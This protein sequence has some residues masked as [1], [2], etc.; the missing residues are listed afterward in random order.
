MRKA[1]YIVGAKR[2]PFGAYGGKLKSFSPTDL[3]VLSSKAAIGQAKL[4][5]AL[6]DDTFFGNVI[7][8]S[9]D[10]TYLA[11][12]I[13]LRSGAPISSPALTVNRLCGS[14]FEAACLAAES[15]EGDRA[16]IALAGGTE[17]MSAAPM[18]IDGV[19][20]RFGVALGKGLQAQDSLWAGLTDSYA[21][22]PMGVTAENL[23]TKYNISRG[24]CDEYALRSQQNWK[25]A[26]MAGVFTAEIE[27]VEVKGKKGKEMMV[28]DEHPRPETT[29][30]GL[31]KLKPV[32]KE[33]GT[34]TAGTASGISDGSASLILASESA[35]SKEKLVPLARMVSWARVGCDPSIMGIGPVEAI[36]LALKRANLQLGDMG[37]YTF[38]LLY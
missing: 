5:P 7:Q 20:A 16:S 33:G 29:I 12:H 8:S 6:I 26:Q 18:V 2:T 25:K 1:I 24:E 9:L 23:A 19:S 27:P 35:C 28:D 4:N 38:S 15:I 17:N 32:F 3:G 22:F 10:A 34:V 21:G 13:A 36:R 11:R 30:E 14:G 31:N 37:S